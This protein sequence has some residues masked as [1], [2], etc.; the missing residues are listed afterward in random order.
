MQWTIKSKNRR[1]YD[2]AARLGHWHRTFLWVPKVI[3]EQS[4]VQRYAWLRIAMRKYKLA[5][6][7]KGYKAFNFIEPKY[8]LPEEL[9]LAILENKK[10]EEIVFDDY[11]SKSKYRGMETEFELGK[12]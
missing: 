10:I 8:M 5:Q 7:N 12:E 6:S 1:A 11:S 2:R 3:G 4:G 9:T